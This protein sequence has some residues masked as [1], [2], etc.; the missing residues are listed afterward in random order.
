MGLMFISLLL[1]FKS[2]TPISHPCNM[3]T[4]FLELG[5]VHF[6][7]LDLGKPRVLP[8]KMQPGRKKKPGS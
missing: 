7:I 2:W 3:Q 6:C 1:H 5:R 4:L 8:Q